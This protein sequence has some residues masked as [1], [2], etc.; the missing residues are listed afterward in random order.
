MEAQLETEVG[1]IKYKHDDLARKAR[2]K[3]EIE[4]LACK[5][6]GCE[7]GMEK[8]IAEVMMTDKKDAGD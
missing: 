7:E 2:G 6:T 8:V 5:S 3:P 1:H 4:R